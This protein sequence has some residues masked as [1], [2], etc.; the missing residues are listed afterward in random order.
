[1]GTTIQCTERFDWA[2]L[3]LPT[4]DLS[5]LDASFT[6][7]ELRQAVFDTPTDKAPG[8]DGFSGGFFRTSWN[9]I[10]DDLL[11]ALHKFHCLNDPS[12][13]KLNT[14]FFILLPKTD[15]PSQTKHYR[16]IRL[17]HAFGKLISKILANRLKPH[18]EE[19]ISPCQS[20]F[21]SGRN[22][23][24]NFL[25][26]QNVAKH[27]HKTK[28]P[29]LLLK[30]DIAK[31]FD[32]ISWTYIIDMMEARG[33]PLRWRNWISLLFRSASS[34]V[35]INGLPGRTIKHQR[36]LRKGDSLSPFLFDL[37][38]EPL[39]RLLEIATDAGVLS[40]LKGKQCTFRASFYADDVALFIKPT[41]Q[42]INGLGEILSTFGRATGLVTNLTK[43]SITPISCQHIDVQ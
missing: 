27:F 35:L 43:S 30:L 39:H 36:G 21:I 18:L 33:F 25:Y 4:P 31:A 20:A 7:E 1:M 8:P 11:R 28:T 40:K 13:H 19:L 2:Q 34:R 24:G 32:T 10:K 3:N 17:I 23:Q 5:D 41:Q 16:P 14:A 22:I 6:M 26:V 9:V 29:T 42:D 15:Q 37:A 38:L 12:F